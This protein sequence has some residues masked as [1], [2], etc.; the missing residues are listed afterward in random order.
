MVEKGI[1][2]E[3]TTLYQKLKGEN[4]DVSPEIGVMQAIGRKY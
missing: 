3:V 4:G 1:L 2:G